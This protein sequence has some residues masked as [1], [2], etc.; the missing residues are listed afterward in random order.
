[1]VSCVVYAIIFKRGET[2][3]ITCLSC[4]GIFHLQC[5]TL[6]EDNFDY[7]ISVKKNWSC[8]NCIKK[9]KNALKSDIQLDN[10]P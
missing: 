10:I 8:P 1:M 6:N 4:N 3:S 5:I 7:L 2:G 9:L